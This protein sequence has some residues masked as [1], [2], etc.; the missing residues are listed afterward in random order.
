ML[1][2]FITALL[3]MCNITNNQTERSLLTVYFYL[4]FM[5]S[6]VPLSLTF[7]SLYYYFLGG[8]LKMMV[9]LLEL[10]EFEVFK[11]IVGNT[12]THI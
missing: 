5:H 10:R 11:V 6:C 12:Q 9:L 4:K 3:H 7:N 8:Y 1:T 2:I